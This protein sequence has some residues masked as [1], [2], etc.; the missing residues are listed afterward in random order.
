M[1]AGDANLVTGMVYQ[2]PSDKMAFREWS[3]ASPALDH[4]GET[5]KDIEFGPM[6]T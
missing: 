1:S 2:T 3:I 4:V 5:L 6:V